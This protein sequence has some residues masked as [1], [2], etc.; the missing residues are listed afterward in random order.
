MMSSAGN[1]T[2][3]DG[4]SE[5][6][7]QEALT[8]LDAAL[9]Q[10]DETLRSL[11]SSNSAMYKQL[12]TLTEKVNQLS[13]QPASVAPVVNT[14]TVKEPH[15]PTPERYSG[16]FGVCQAFLT[17][18]S[19]VFELQPRSYASDRAKIAF[20]IG[21]LSGDAR[22]WGAAVWQRQGPLCNSYMAFVEE[23]RKNF[24]HPVSGRDASTR[25]GSIQQGSRSVAEYAREFRTLAAE[26][27][28]NDPA[29]RS[30]FY[31]GLNE[32]FKR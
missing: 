1:V 15:A 22:D 26:V 29:L 2:A 3:A 20:L 14:T 28:W 24:D 31:R 6:S 25:L 30:A 12:A 32:T 23:M 27:D 16:D 17:Q 21:L 4:V 19:L 7:L 8:S 18:V 11:S 9:V 5:V 13:V 10:H